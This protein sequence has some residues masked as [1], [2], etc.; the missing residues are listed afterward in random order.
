MTAGPTHGK[1]FLSADLVKLP[2]H[3]AQDSWVDWLH[4]AAVAFN[5]RISCGANHS[6]CDSYRQTGDETSSLSAS[7]DTLCVPVAI[8]VNY[9]NLWLSYPR[10][11]FDFNR[12]TLIGD[13]TRLEVSIVDAL[14]ELF[15]EVVFLLMVT[16]LHCC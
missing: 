13:S 14:E 12:S 1:D 9:I 11:F 4:Q 5:R 6:S 8:S 15:A 7:P 2:S 3:Q 16:F 10:S